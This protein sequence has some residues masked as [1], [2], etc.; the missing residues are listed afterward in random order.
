MNKSTVTDQ[1]KD[2]LI[3]IKCAYRDGLEQYAIKC[4]MEVLRLAFGNP[5]VN[6]YGYY[7]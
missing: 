3:E 4:E 5:T 1:I 2:L 6:K 7:S